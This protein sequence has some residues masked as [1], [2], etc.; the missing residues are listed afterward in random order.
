MLVSLSI[1]ACNKEVS[2]VTSPNT[3]STAQ[4]QAVNSSENINQ[5][6]Y[7]IYELYKTQGG[8]LSYDEWLKSIKGE[9]G[10][11]GE[12]GK[13]GINGQDGHSPIITIGEDGYWYIDDINTGVKAQGEKGDQGIQGEKGETGPQGSQGPRGDT[14]EQGPKGDKGDTGATGPKGDQGEKGE[15]GATGPKGDQGAQGQQGETGSQGP[16]GDQGIQGDKGDAGEQGPK[17]DKGDKGD[18]GEKGDTGVS[19]VSTTINEDGDLIITY[20]DGTIKNA[21]HLKDINTYTV[22][23]YCDDDLVATRQVPAGQKVARPTAQETAGYTVN[24]WYTKDENYQEQWNF[25]GCVVTENTNIYADFTYNQYTISFVDERFNHTVDD[26]TVT[27]DKPYS[28]PSPLQTGYTISWQDD[29]GNL[30]DD[31][32]PYRTASDV[33]LYAVWDANKY[34]AE[35]D[36][37]GGT[38]SSNSV[39]ATFDKTYSLPTP[40][41]LNYTFLG[42]FDGETRVSSSATWKFVENKSFTAHWTNVT[43]TYVFDAGDGICDAET[44]VIGWEDEYTL[45]IPTHDSLAF[46][47]WSLNGERIPNSDV[48]TYSNSGGTLIALWKSPFTIEDGCVTGCDKSIKY[49]YIPNGVTSIHTDAFSDCSS[50][51]TVTIPDSVTSIGVAAFKTCSSL[52]SIIIPDSV[53]FLGDYAFYDCPSLHYNEY[54]NAL[55]LGNESNPYLCLIKAKNTEITSCIINANCKFI[56]T[57]SF[58]QCSSL[59]FI[60]IPDSVISIGQSAFLGCSEL[61]SVIIGNSVT[62]IKF[63]AFLDCPSLH[64]NEY[65]NALYLGNESNPYLCLI[66]AKNTEI[67]SCIINANCKLIYIESFGQCSSL[68]FIIIPDSVV[69]ISVYAF[70]DCI[71]LNRI[72]YFGTNEQWEQFNFWNKIV[73]FYS[74]EKPTINGKYWHYVDG[75]PT[76]W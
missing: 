72:F 68:E 44:I 37:N 60:I 16:K 57:E 1:S 2:S 21:G 42:W 52:T 3:E 35:L 17:G 71:S 62:S 9:K 69:S 41:R 34:T 19:I 39:S 75:V 28:L 25:Q 20:S 38:V 6:I 33:T 40:E 22:N 12:P 30:Y 59:E 32:K 54:D 13:D 67:T 66:K 43:N 36:A 15:T 64:Y 18:Q 51:E 29:S 10:D 76:I 56:H 70:P 31:S 4:S 61:A 50:I 49:A 5:D 53:S 24:Y 73:Y 14:G 47:C 23:F 48:W 11:Q 65:D 74:S 46:D 8:D 45:P 27:Y 58:I 7:K 63:Q 26:L 55:Y